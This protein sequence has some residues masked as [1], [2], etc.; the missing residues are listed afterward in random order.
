MRQWGLGQERA[1]HYEDG[2]CDQ[3]YFKSYHCR[4]K[5]L[6]GYP[7]VFEGKGINVHEQG[8]FKSNK[9]IGEIPSKVFRE[10]ESIDPVDG[11]LPRVGVF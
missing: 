6:R 3:G 4:K 1:E 8:F 7:E 2:Q 10:V 5:I 11:R 9:S